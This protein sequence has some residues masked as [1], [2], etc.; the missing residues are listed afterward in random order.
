MQKGNQLAIG[1]LTPL[2]EG[3]FQEQTAEA[4]FLASDEL[5]TSRQLLLEL[6]LFLNKFMQPRATELWKTYFAD[7]VSFYAR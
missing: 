7:A 6:H 1:D 4:S 3:L 5:S 2:L